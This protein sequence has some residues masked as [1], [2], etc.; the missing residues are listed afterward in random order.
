[1]LHPLRSPD[2]LKPHI[3]LTPSLLATAVFAWPTRLYPIFALISGILQKSGV[4]AV[5]RVQTFEV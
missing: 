5:F 3:L 4:Q 2:P 1:M